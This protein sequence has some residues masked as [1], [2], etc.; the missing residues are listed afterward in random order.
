MTWKFH[1]HATEQRRLFSRILQI[2]E[3]QLVSI[4]SFAGEANN[5]GVHITFVVS[6]EED[7]SY[8]IEALLYRLEDVRSVSVLSEP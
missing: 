1:V 2:L 5:G 3:S 4:R 7:R 6:S 8:R